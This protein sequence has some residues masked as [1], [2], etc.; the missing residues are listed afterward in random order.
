MNTVTTP[1]QAFADCAYK[2]VR[3]KQAQAFTNYLDSRPSHSGYV[4]NLNGAW[5]TGKTFFVNNWVEWLREREYVA[6]KIDAWESDYL[7]DPLAIVTAEML[8]QLKEHGGITDFAEQEKQIINYGWKLAKNFLP[9]LTMALGRHFLGE[10]YESLLKEVGL[11]VKDSANDK[12]ESVPNFGAF[13]KEIF[14]THDKHKEFAEQFKIH[15]GKLIEILIKQSKKDKV[16]V[17]IDELDRCRPT[18][19]IELLEVVK[20]LFDIPQLVFVMSTD[21]SQLE[22]SIKAVYGETFD[23][24]EYLSRFFQR[25]LSLSTPDYLTFIRSRN[26]FSQVNFDPEIIYPRV[27]LDTARELFSMICE[28]NSLSFRRTEQV[29]A[30]IE[31][32]LISLPDMTAISFIELVCNIVL[33]EVYPKESFAYSTAYLPQGFTYNGVK[34]GRNIPANIVELLNK[35]QGLWNILVRI[36]SSRNSEVNLN[37]AMEQF[38]KHRN[39]IMRDVHSIKDKTRIGSL[40]SRH[41]PSQHEANVNF[42]FLSS[43]IANKELELLHGSAL[44]D[45]LHLFESIS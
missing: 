36:H 40:I 37:I 45:Y 20:H 38:T 18:Y 1:A 11:S 43:K 39:G 23:S 24:E 32:A 5:G 6:V 13:G 4:A 3:E 27:C 30:R 22:S 16:Y 12:S 29:S 41:F 42:S 44:N 2:D 35:Y 21:T 7:N 34:Q 17:F 28:A 14:E 31:S 8:S 33:Y 26:I 15:L 9:V 25:R 19:A 10:G